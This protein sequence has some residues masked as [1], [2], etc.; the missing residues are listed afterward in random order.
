MTR[1]DASHNRPHA[2]S[3][4]FETATANMLL[5]AHNR[6]YTLCH[7][8]PSSIVVNIQRHYT[9]PTRS[10]S[11]LLQTQTPITYVLLHAS[12]CIAF[13]PPRRPA[14]LYAHSIPT[15]VLDLCT[16]FFILITGSPRVHLKVV[17]AQ[18]ERRQMEPSTSNPRSKSF[19]SCASLFI[20]LLI[21][22]SSICFLPESR[23]LEHV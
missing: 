18:L 3:H 9:V 19:L 1:T 11:K 8:L 10:V 16:L 6:L 21:L 2:C 23:E 7:F 4:C 15:V 14:F 13:P 5:R 17:E 20:S 22:H 12:L